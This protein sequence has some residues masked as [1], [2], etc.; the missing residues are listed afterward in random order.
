MSPNRPVSCEHGDCEASLE[1]TS[2]RIRR[3]ERVLAVPQKLW[4]CA[5]CR[6]PDTGGA[7]R[8]T[9]P[10][11]RDINQALADAAWREH[12]GEALPPGGRPGRKPAEPLE[13]RVV[14]LLSRSE[15]ARL[16]A[17]RGERTRS[18]LIRD[19][20]RQLVDQIEHQKAS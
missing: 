4:S 16:D 9:D 18:E 17:A 15:L 19:A 20:V 5:H 7:Q 13:E 12:Y 1:D 11:L 3:G 6:D 10:S 2:M 8:F 14:A